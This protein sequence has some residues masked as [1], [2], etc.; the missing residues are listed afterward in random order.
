MDIYTFKKDNFKGSNLTSLF[1][2]Y[3]KNVVRYARSILTKRKKNTSS[4]TL[5]DSL[6][7]NTHYDSTDMSFTVSIDVGDAE[8]YWEYVESGVKG[9]KSTKPNVGKNREVLGLPSFSFKKKNVA[10]GVIESWIKKKGIRGRVDKKWKSAG[11]KGGQFI[12][13]KSF[14]FLIGR[15]IASRG[16]AYSGFLSTP[17]ITQNKTLSKEIYEAYGKDLENYYDKELIIK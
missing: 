11:N 1:Q 7:Y 13:D 6:S 16:I 14:A 5:Y 3:G 12:S 8:S 15:A 2:K 10:K 9:S 4:K 17:I